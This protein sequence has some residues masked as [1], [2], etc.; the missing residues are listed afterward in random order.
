MVDVTHFELKNK[1][2][3]FLRWS[4]ETHLHIFSSID[5]YFPNFFVLIVINVLANLQIFSI[6]I[7]LLSRV[8]VDANFFFYFALELF[9]QNSKKPARFREGNFSTPSQIFSIFLIFHSKDEK[10]RRFSKCEMKNLPTIKEKISSSSFA[11]STCFSMYFSCIIFLDITFFSISI[12]KCVTT[13]LINHFS[14]FFHRQKIK[15]WTKERFLKE[16]SFFFSVKSAN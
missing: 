6:W 10:S 8:L 2:F 16:F 12:S 11:F 3:T 1:D 5:F 4:W 7:F 15:E 13:S 9:H 14:S